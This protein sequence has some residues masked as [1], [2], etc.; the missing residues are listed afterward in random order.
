MKLLLKFIR[1]LALTR[2]VEIIFIHAIK[3]SNTHALCSQNIHI[4][5][6]EHVYFDVSIHNLKNRTFDARK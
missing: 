3:G 2:C 1:T 4:V 5:P 6:T